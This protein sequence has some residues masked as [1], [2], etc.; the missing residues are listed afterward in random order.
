MFH[1]T[2]DEDEWDRLPADRK[3][4][5]RALKARLAADPFAA[6]DKVR[7]ALIPRGLAV[8]NLYRRVLRGGWRMVYTIRTKD[9][10]P[11]VRILLVGSHK[12]YDRFFGYKSS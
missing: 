10:L 3:E 4:E 9:V 2:I 5:V 8:P 7:R 1:V 11:T 6:G 12:R